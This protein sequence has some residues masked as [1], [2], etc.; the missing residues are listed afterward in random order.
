MSHAGW[1][2]LGK[3]LHGSWALSPAVVAFNN[4]WWH[5]FFFFYFFNLF[6]WLPI[7][8][9]DIWDKV[10][11]SGLFKLRQEYQS[12]S[13][14]WELWKP[15]ELLVLALKRQEQLFCDRCLL[16]GNSHSDSNQSVINGR[17]CV[18]FTMNSCVYPPRLIAYSI[19]SAH[20]IPIPLTLLDRETWHFAGNK[21]SKI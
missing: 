18:F 1:T 6:I 8:V 10:I 7:D 13:T 15:P 17:L 16:H 5:Y 3:K 11:F 12:H 2:K 9:S 21:S 4:S 20:Y 14:L 19:L